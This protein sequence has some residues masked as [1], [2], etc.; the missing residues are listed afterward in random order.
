MKTL[1]NCL[2]FRGILALGR[3]LFLISFNKKLRKISKYSSSLYNNGK[4]LDKKKLTSYNSS[5]MIPTNG[6]SPSNSSPFSL[7]LK[8]GKE[9]NS[10]IQNAPIFLKEVEMLI[11][12]YLKDTCI[13]IILL[14]RNKAKFTNNSINH[15][16][17]QWM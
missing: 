2:A 12:M 5:T 11:I 1:L 17:K 14:I 16:S 9:L 8:N 13:N 3:L 6:H 4:I 10:I 15:I 7:D